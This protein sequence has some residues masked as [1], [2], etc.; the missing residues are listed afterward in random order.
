MKR[1]LIVAL[2]SG[3][4]EQQDAITNYIRNRGWRVWH[5]LADVWLLADV[6]ASVSPKSLWSD[7]I[8]VPALESARGFVMTTGND[9]TYWGSIDGRCWDWMSEYWGIPD[10]IPPGLGSRRGSVTA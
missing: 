4:S 7:L 6:P 5:W 9:A 10:S 8:A 2:D 3:T 1:K